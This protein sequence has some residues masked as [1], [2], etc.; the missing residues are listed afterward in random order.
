[1]PCPSPFLIPT[2]IITV[3][4]AFVQNTCP[5]FLAVMFAG[6]SAPPPA[7]CQVNIPSKDLQ[8]VG[9]VC[10]EEEHDTNEMKA[11]LG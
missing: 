11:W 7:V 4:M 5:A 10:L 6:V 2:D 1:M 8:I 9:I 3:M